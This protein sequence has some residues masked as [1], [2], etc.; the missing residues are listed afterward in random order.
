MLSNFLVLATFPLLSILYLKSNWEE[1]EAK[2]KLR[3]I[4]TFII[5]FKW[6][7]PSPHFVGRVITDMLLFCEE[8]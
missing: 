8:A 2:K 7:P 5:I 6:L 1:I 3:E 4:G